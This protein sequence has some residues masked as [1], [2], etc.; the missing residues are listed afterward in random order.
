MYVRSGEETGGLQHGFE[1]TFWFERERKSHVN[2]I[3]FIHEERR[4]SQV[5]ID[6][7]YIA[8]QVRAAEE[9]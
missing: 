2:L 8:K 3:T 7:V 6:E 4:F 9:K 5:A 1:N